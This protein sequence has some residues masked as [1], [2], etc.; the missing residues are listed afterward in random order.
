VGTKDNQ[1]LLVLYD[2]DCRFCT[3]GAARLARFFGPARVATLNFQAD[4]VLDRY[5]AIT[6]EAAMA[7]MHVVAPDGQIYPGAAGV[8]RLIRALPV[9][10]IISYLYYLPILKQLVDLAYRLIAK[11]RYRLFARAEPC[12]PGGTCHLH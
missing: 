12:E 8:A 4:G 5:P 1:R 2:G 11:H 7:A 10:G 6:R 9:F 3:A